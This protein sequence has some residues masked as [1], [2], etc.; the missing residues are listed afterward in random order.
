MELILHLGIDVSRPSNSPERRAVIRDNVPALTKTIAI[1]RYLNAAPSIGASL[2]D[3]AERLQITKSHCCNILK[4]LMREGWLAYDGTHRSYSLAP[5]LL[6]DISRL[7]GGRQMPQILIHEELIRLS[8]A[9]GIPCV[10]SRIEQDGSFVAI[11]KAEEAAELIVSVPIGH[12]FPP[13]APAQM[14]V[15]L[16]WMPEDLR[17]KELARWRPRAYTRTTIVRKKAAR[18]E[19]EATHRRGYAVSRGEFSPGVMTLAA[20]ILDSL[21][22]V[23]MALQCPGLIDKVIRDQSKIATELQRAAER[24]NALFSA[25]L[26]AKLN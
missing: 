9:T 15:R 12:R 16:A 13:D 5:R 8:R 10:L 24:L 3:I 17:Q 20:S 26:A 2:H 14:R 11:D 25:P 18:V 7:I 1:I 21:G 6:A 4:A 23:Q 19:I 22:N